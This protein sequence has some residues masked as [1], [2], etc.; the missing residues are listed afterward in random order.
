MEPVNVD[1][2]SV[3]D[4]L[5]TLLDEHSASYRLMDH[6]PEGR[7]DLVSQLRGNELSQAAK[8]MIIMVKVGKKEKHYVLAVLP[9]D[10]KVDMA[11]VKALYK[12]DYTN[13]ASQDVAEKLTGMV[14]GT[15]LPFSFNPE[16]ELI[17]DP[18]LLVNE[19]I[20]FNAAR[21]DRSMYLRASDY[22]AI[23]KPRIE[24]LAQNAGSSMGGGELRAMSGE[25]RAENKFS[26]QLNAPSSELIAYGKGKHMPAQLYKVRHS[27]AHI[28][29]EAVLEQFPEAKPTIGPPV[30]NGFYYDFAVPKP[31]TPEDLQKIEARMK[32]IVQKHIGFDRK[33]VSADEARA[34][35]KDNPFKRELIDGLAKGADEYGEKTETT[36]DGRQTTEEPSSVVRRP[37]SPVISIYTQDGFSDLC[38]GPHVGNTSE[39]DPTAFKINQSSGAYW[40]GDE[41]NPMLQRIYGLA[42]EKPAELEQF[43]DM[44][45]EAKKRDHRKLGSELEIFI[46]DDEV[47]PGLPLWQPNGTIMIEE[48]EALAKRMENEA[49]YERVKT[50]HLSKEDLFLRSG[51]LPYYA[52]SMYPPMELDDGIKYYMK[53]M[54]CPFHH[55]LYAA[56]PRSYRDLPVRLAEYGT[57]Y[58][59]EQ[60]GELFG[61]MRVRSMQMNDAHIYCTPEQ[62]ESEFLAVVNLYLRYFQI[63][64]IKD[65]QMRLSLHSTEG[66]GKKYVDNPG[67]WIQT[68]EMVRRAMI[69]GKVP[70]VERANEAA[71]YGPKIDV[72]IS[73]AIGREFTLATNQVDFAVPP[74]FGLV[75]KDKDGEEKTPLCLHRA[76]LSTHERLIGFLIEHFAGNFPL[77]L[78]PQQA[79]IIPIADRHVEGAKQV[80]KRLMAAGIRA[81]VDDGPDRMQNKIR[82]AQLMKV[83]YMLVIGDKEQEADSVAVRLRSGED[84]KAMTV[85]AFVARALPLIKDYALTL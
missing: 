27:L 43:L 79:A 81:K 40:R 63:F 38:R 68:E 85:E 3:Y 12:G 6:A 20:V 67:M 28:M 34:L 47:G 84:L 56:K 22:L 13:F 26:S 18:S 49:G 36:D 65:Y 48:L 7:T 31:F 39:I 55:K 82:K 75:Y 16:L 73:S 29:A 76:P 33:E 71:F 23:A 8:C 57:C 74:R 24:K 9:G 54:N 30:D 77:W 72:Q 62:F 21:L 15:I 58:R 11:A 45:E 25:P 44:Q 10:A 14:A 53:P 2:S 78:A 5:I 37:S 51:H 80:Q 41:K 52:E 61:L 1:I 42:F 19:E 59:F 69:N 64:D 50:P 60:S 66:L 32:E 4:R 17:V 46:F 35:F 83:P 70:F